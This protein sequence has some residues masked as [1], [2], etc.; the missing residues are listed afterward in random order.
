ME[1]IRRPRVSN[2]GGSI[3]WH[4]RLLLYPESVEDLM[5][6]AKDG[7]TYPSPVRALGSI[8]STTRCTV[9]EGGT[10]VSM[11][12]LNRI[13]DIGAD[14]VTAQ[15]GALYIDVAQELLK[16]GLQFFVNVELGNLS[17]GS[18]ACGGT[19]DASM[20]EEFG[21]VCSYAIGLKVVTADGEL[22]EVTEQDPELLKILR[23]SYGL[24]GMI[25]E[26]TFR[27]KPVQPMSV[28]HIGYTL[29]EFQDLLD[30]SKAPNDSMMLYLFPFLDKV[31]VEYRRYGPAGGKPNRVLWRFRNWVWKSV[32]PG[33]GYLVTKILPIRRLRYALIDRFNQALQS[34]VNRV[35]QDRYTLAA[36]QIIRYPE[37]SNWTRYTFSIWA[38]PEGE[39]SRILGDYFEFCRQYYQDHGYRCNLL[40]VAY[41]ISED[42]SSLF[43]Y[44]FDGDVLTLDPVSTGDSGWEE[45][46][47]AYNEFCSARG[48][49]PLFN[50]TRGITPLQAEKAFGERLSI[51]RDHLTRF[52][53]KGRFLSDYFRQ[54]LDVRLGEEHLAERGES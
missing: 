45:F 28:H 20:P 21:Q 42:Q 24:L 50:Q 30:D 3:A 49:V 33:F 6:I 14:T 43:S 47:V 16:R 23:S 39:Y 13:V 46:I 11:K 48:G 31:T 53:P 51:F 17:I 15:A 9:S 37:K 25:Y 2:W 44:S 54:I 52:D 32:G 8:H 7:E 34:I 26:A 22:L 19:K 40:N 38:F 35:L 27:V 18:A 5:S 12:R 10:A 41:R 1:L 29:K 4:P 36:D